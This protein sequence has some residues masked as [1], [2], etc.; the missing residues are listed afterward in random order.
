MKDCT[1]CPHRIELN[2]SYRDK[3]WEDLPCSTCELTEPSG[4]TLS[5]NDNIYYSKAD[6][7]NNDDRDTFIALLSEVFKYWL[8]L[9]PTEKQIISDRVLKPTMTMTDLA[10]THNMSRM[11][12]YRTLNR[13]STKFPAFKVFVPKKR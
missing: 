9:N 6:L 3:K 8:N 10:K 12:L 13:I 11:T 1:S 5:Y 2:P 4:K 7:N